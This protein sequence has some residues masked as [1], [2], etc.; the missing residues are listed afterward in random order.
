MF[1]RNKQVV[2]E[3]FLGKRKNIFGD[4]ITLGS[5]SVVDEKVLSNKPIDNEN[6]LSMIIL[7]TNM[8]SVTIFGKQKQSSSSNSRVHAT[9][10]FALKNG[11]M[12]A[13]VF[14]VAWK[15]VN[16]SNY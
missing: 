1:L 4:E 11:E 10:S 12:K 15:S 6:I 2:A 7:L 16:I 13:N 8:F 5:N 14:I 3:K 9:Q